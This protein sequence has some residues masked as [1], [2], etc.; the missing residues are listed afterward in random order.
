[1]FLSHHREKVNGTVYFIFQPSEENYQGAKAMIDD[2]LFSIISPEEIYGLHINPM[3]TGLV[4]A[5]SELVYAYLKI[6]NVSYKNTGNKEAIIEFT[7]DTDIK[8]SGC[9]IR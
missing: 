7:K 3:P 6:I 1:M 5:K 2:G 8:T 4:S 9:P